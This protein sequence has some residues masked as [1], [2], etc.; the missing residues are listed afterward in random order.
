MFILQRI[1]NRTDIKEG[2]RD[3]KENVE[4]NINSRG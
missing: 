3:K 1:V 4:C 2:R